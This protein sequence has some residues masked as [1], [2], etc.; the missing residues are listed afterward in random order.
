MSGIL[1]AMS[2]VITSQL[3]GCNVKIIKGN[4]EMGIAV[5]QENFAKQKGTDWAQ[6]QYLLTSDRELQ[7]LND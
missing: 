1:W 5:F 4:T 7:A 6:E 2:S 3:C